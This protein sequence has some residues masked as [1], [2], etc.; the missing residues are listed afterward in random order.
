[1]YV[2]IDAY[3]LPKGPRMSCV[4]ATDACIEST[5]WGQ[6]VSR[7]CLHSSFPILLLDAEVAHGFDTT[8]R[9]THTMIKGAVVLRICK[10]LVH[11]RQNMH[12]GRTADGRFCHIRNMMFTLAFQSFQS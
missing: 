12:I 11:V 10:A 4:G 7:S 1:M 2:E 3:V 6:L 9:A 5:E 8:T